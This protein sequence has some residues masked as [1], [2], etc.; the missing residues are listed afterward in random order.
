MFVRHL[1]FGLLLV[2][3]L[4]VGSPALGQVFQTD[5]ARTPLP[6]PVGMAEWNLVTNS[7]GRNAMMQSWKDPM[8][9]M[10]LQQP[11]V[12]GQ[13]YSPPAF[14]QF[15]DG[16]AITLQGLFKWRGEQIDPVA[17]AK[18]SPGFFSPTCGFSGQLVL[19]GGNC[20]VSF[21][22]YNV[23][24]PDSTTP[25]AP[26]EI[27][28][29]I[30]NDPTYLNCKN[31]NGGP[32]TDGF[33]PLAWDTRSPRDLSIHQWTP[34][35][36]DSGNIKSDPNYKGKYVGFAVIG[37]PA[38]SCKETKFSMYAH[39]TKNLQGEPWVATL[40]Y[41]S[42]V[43][44]EG[45]YMAFE[46]L[47]MSPADWRES[48]GTYKNDGDFNDF[49]FY[50]SGISCLGGGQPCDTGL[51]G[52]CSVGRTDCT[53]G[54]VAG[55][56]RPII[57]PGEE[58]CDNVDNDCDGVVDEGDGLCAAG[59]VCD[60][61]TCVDAC[62]TGEFRCPQGFACKAGHCIENACAEVEC[63]A[64]QA[65]RAGECLDACD[66]VLCPSGQECQLGRCVDPCANVECQAGKV[67]ERGLCVS[68]CQCRGCDEGFVCGGDGRCTDPACEGVMCA[69]GTVCV[70][71]QCVDRCDGVTCPNGQQCVKGACVMGGGDDTGG[72][73]D[74]GID[75][76]G[77]LDLGGEDG[78]ESG[79][80]PGRKGTDPGCAC[81]AAPS[82]SSSALGLWLAA[83]VLLLVRPRRRTRV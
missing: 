59:Q 70:Q 27:Y 60:K 41:Q 81:R 1:R 7:W 67:C 23:E 14:P 72:T 17:D 42:T 64:G 63:P 46:D 28:E 38:L 48:G 15:E 44:P 52:A 37:N 54:D 61:G 56:C 69:D 35:A 80:G 65:C 76:G 74:G 13:Y 53:I 51:S 58:L 78:D 25:P 33:C 47:P 40:I 2:G 43:D 18:T 57:S 30:P 73:D 50:V 3:L 83:S 66:G 82:A 21:G 20:Q 29:F 24:D 55:M 12:Y 62:G 22:W 32:K 10:Q 77:G 45:F 8:T 39:N 36:F 19:M 4:S 9:G 75:L 71:G 6:Q 5:A 49:V 11:I 34:K 31:D 26:G 68:D 79:S 16:D